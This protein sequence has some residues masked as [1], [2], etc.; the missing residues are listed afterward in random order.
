MATQQ[1]VSMDCDAANRA[2]A[3]NEE[4]MKAMGVLQH[5]F[6]RKVGLQDSHLVAPT[7][8]TSLAGRQRIAALLVAHGKWT[9]AGS[10]YLDF[11][12][13]RQWL[14]VSHTGGQACANSQF[15]TL[16]AVVQ[17]MVGD[18]AVQLVFGQERPTDDSAFPAELFDAMAKMIGTLASQLDKETLKAQEWFKGKAAPGHGVG[19]QPKKACNADRAT[20]VHAPAK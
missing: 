10:R 17:A 3:K 16:G 8:P 2:A 19:P 12:E 18:A 15:E 11:R 9:E 4:E 5:A 6:D 13:L 14:C 1:A 7:L 20:T